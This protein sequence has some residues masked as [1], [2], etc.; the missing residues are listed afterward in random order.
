MIK[1][2]IKKSTQPK[3]AKKNEPKIKVEPSFQESSERGPIDSNGCNECEVESQDHDEHCEI[4]Q[5][6][7][8][9]LPENE[10][11]PINANLDFILEQSDNCISQNLDRNNFN[12]IGDTRNSIDKV[13]QD[14]SV[15]VNTEIFDYS[16]TGFIESEKDL[17]TL[18]NIKN[19]DILNELTKVMDETYPLQRK[20]LLST[21]DSIILTIAK[22]KLDISFSALAVFF[23]RVIEVTI[24]NIFYDTVRKLGRILQSV[25]S[26]VSKEEIQ[27]NMPRCFEKFQATTSVLDCT[28]IKIQKPKCLKCQ[29]KFYSYY[30]G[31]LTIKFMT[32]VTPA[33]LITFVSESFGGRASDKSIFSYSG[34]L[35]RLESTRDAVMVDRG[36]IIDDECMQRRIKLIRPPFMKNREQLTKQEALENREIASARVHI[37]RMNQRIKQFRILNN[38][39]PWHMINYIDDIFIIC[40]GLANLDTPILA[41]DKF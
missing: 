18:C 36:F 27:R 33:G 6:A 17:I 9:T 41:D 40:C 15:Q 24:R 22:L 23:K 12:I 3:K 1:E 8:A 5:K 20:R 35:Q 28:E 16:L 39:F 32:E 31:D 4:F 10:I 21:R 25:I 2:N 13:F 14:K 29:I 34:I 30:K 11:A 37:E 19:F 26:P 38:K 7:Q